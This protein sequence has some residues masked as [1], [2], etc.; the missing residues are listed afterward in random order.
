MTSSSASWIW[1]PTTSGFALGSLVNA[2]RTSK[3]C[4]PLVFDQDAFSLPFISRSSE[5]G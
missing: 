2:S 5:R 3:T 4:V 1:T